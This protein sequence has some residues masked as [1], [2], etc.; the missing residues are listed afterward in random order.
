[1]TAEKI[2]LIV[3]IYMLSYGIGGLLFITPDKYGRKRSILLSGLFHI[4]GMV[5]TIFSKDYVI[6]VM[7]LVLM[8]AFHIKTSIAYVY[9]FEN[10]H[11]RNK[12][13]CATFINVID[14]IP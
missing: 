5:I 7:G 8:G 2:K 6:K 11:T 3:T 12:S 1:M 13:S 14:A 4:I 10:V 9:M